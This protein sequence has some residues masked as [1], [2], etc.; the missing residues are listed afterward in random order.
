MIGVKVPPS[1][2]AAN[3]LLTRILEERLI[4]AAATS[5]TSALL[6][7]IGRSRGVFLARNDPR[8]ALSHTK[9]LGALGDQLTLEDVTRLLRECGGLSTGAIKVAAA[10]LCAVGQD[11]RRALR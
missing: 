8:R 5:G 7:E 2:I 9:M 6:R 11:R 3:R 10:A 1:I 4:R